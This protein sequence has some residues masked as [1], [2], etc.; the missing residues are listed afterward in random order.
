MLEP[1]PP[2]EGRNGAAAK[3]MLGLKPEE[4]INAIRP[5][6]D[7]TCRLCSDYLDLS[8]F[9]RFGEFQF[10]NSV[11]DLGTGLIR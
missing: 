2:L 9:F 6:V 3:A 5:K 4:S 10:Q 7:E 11:L 1:P 8:G